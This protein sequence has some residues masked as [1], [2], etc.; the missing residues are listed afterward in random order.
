MRGNNPS[1]REKQT[2]V[3]RG[4]ASNGLLTARRFIVTTGGG[5]I[6]I[7][8]KV[9]G[10]KFQ[11]IGENTVAINF[12]SD[13]ASQRWELA[14]NSAPIDLPLNDIVV[15]NGQAMGGDSTIQAIFWG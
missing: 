14:P 5:S 13:T 2:I 11:N 9:T 6:T 15:M 12:F 7:P 1:A 3:N 10:G 8:A 4:T